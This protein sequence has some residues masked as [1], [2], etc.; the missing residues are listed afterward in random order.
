[1]F[2]VLKN[3]ETIRVPPQAGTLLHIVGQDA[4]NNTRITIDAYSNTVRGGAL[5][6]R[7]LRGDT[8]N[9]TAPLLDDVLGSINTDG[10]GGTRFLN[11]SSGGM[12]I[13]ARQ[14]FNDINRG[15]Y[16]TIQATRTGDTIN[17]EVARFDQ[18][19]ITINP[20][21]VTIAQ[22]S[23]NDSAFVYDRTTGKFKLI[24]QLDTAEYSQSIRN[25][26]VS[27]GGT[28]IWGTIIGTLSAQTDL[29][30]A[31]NSKQAAGSY[32]TSEVDGSVTNELQTLGLVGSVLSITNGNDVTISK[33]SVGLSNVDNTSDLNKPIST[34]TQA[35]LNLKADNS[36]VATLKTIS[37][38]NAD[39]VALA[40]DNDIADIKGRLPVYLPLLT[41]AIST[42][43]TRVDI[44]SL[45]FNV[46]AGKRYKIEFTGSYFTA[47]TTT[48]GSL[49]VV[50][51]NAGVGTINGNMEGEVTLATGATGVK[52]SINNINLVNTTANSFMTTTGVSSTT[53]GQNISFNGVF[54]CTS[55]GIFRFQWGSEVNASSATLTSGDLIVTL[56]N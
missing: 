54:R 20:S 39:T 25:S 31:L 16:V 28:P 37:S 45:G 53:L 32:L 41:P 1:L 27:V 15:T 23:P 42:S 3:I 21:N 33:S 34:S 38:F 43:T 48:G 11:S 8:L 52:T 24:K 14:N 46:V 22:G 10:Y 6:F 36:V 44:P 47:V 7:R 4:S 51:T 56:L 19:G 30:N 40:S 5:T 55:S 49:G 13:R 35:A 9:P 18:E 29:Q 26:I 17:K 50:L 12:T 2:F